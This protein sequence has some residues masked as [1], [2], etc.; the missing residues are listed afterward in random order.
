M[1]RPNERT[2]KHHIIPRY[3]GG[4][5]TPENL[6]EVTI[7]QHAMFHFCNYQLW[8]NPEDKLA[9]RALSGQLTMDEIKLERMILGGRKGAETIREKLKDPLKLEEYKEKCRESFYN[10]PHK[11]EMIQRAKDNQPKA[12]EAARTPEAIEK[13]KH[14]LKE[15]GHQQ[16]EKN[17]QYGTMWITDG[18]IEGSYRIKKDDPIPEGFVPGVVFNT[19]NFAFKE[20]EEHPFYNTMWITDGDDEYLHNKDEPIPEGY[21]K[22][23]SEAFYQNINREQLVKNGNYVYENKLGIFKLTSEEHSAAGRKG[24]TASASQRWQC[25]KTGYV[26]NAGPLTRY[27]RNRGID[28]SNRIR[29]K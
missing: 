5:D 22:G 1:C 13:K 14:T 28:P 24:G 19:E 9:W 21:Y 23:R 10:S 20:G 15:I 16:G 27:Q 8:G 2:H 7:T 11:D 4:P 25:T 3:M 6:V 18:T 29:I 17:S 12:S 26:S